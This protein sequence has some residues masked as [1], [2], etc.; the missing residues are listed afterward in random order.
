MAD[1]ND[2]M[3]QAG[4]VQAGGQ[5]QLQQAPQF[6]QAPQFNTSPSLLP[7]ATSVV[8]P[9]PVV[10]V[11]SITQLTPTTAISGGSTAVT[12]TAVVTGDNNNIDISSVIQDN[13]GGL[14][15]MRILML[16]WG[17]GVFLLWSGA[18]IVGIVH[19]IY[20]A[21]TLPPEIVTILLGVTGVKCVQRYGER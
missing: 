7:Q 10:Q 16:L 14:S 3:I 1:N 9:T 5:P 4:F 17:G 21:P 19:G 13:S 8:P 6:V 18:W 2:A 15:S 12:P 20:T 11:P